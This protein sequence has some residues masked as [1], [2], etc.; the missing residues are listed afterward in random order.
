[1]SFLDDLA[2]GPSGGRK[3]WLR[4]LLIAPRRSRGASPRCSITLVSG[5]YAFLRASIL[6]GSPTGAY[7]A[8]GDR[9][10]ARALKKN[11]HLT[12]VATAGSVENIARLVGENGRLRSG[13]RFRAGW[14]AGAG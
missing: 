10:A 3:A 4:A 12:V 14:R 7:H 6:T 2:F 9:L 11:G 5:D 1:M 13:V 8:L